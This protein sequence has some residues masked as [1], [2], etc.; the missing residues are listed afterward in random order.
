[1]HAFLTGTVV[2]MMNLTSTV[3]GII[4]LSSEM[5]GSRHGR[6]RRDIVNTRTH[7]RVSGVTSVKCSENRTEFAI[8]IRSDN[9]ESYRL[10]DIL[11]RRLTRTVYKLW[12]TR[13]DFAI[14]WVNSMGTKVREMHKNLV[15]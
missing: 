12:T 10:D 4:L 6:T 8:R 14:R 9:F 13:I 2:K 1:M 3:I 11:P 15:K 5:G 7:M